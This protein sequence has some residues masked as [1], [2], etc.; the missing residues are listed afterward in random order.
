MGKLEENLPKLAKKALKEEDDVTRGL[1][2]VLL[3]QVYSGQHKTNLKTI[4]QTALDNEIEKNIDAG[5][6]NIN[7][8]EE[9]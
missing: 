9:N 1:V 7:N 6:I 5:I 8:L 2:N 4:V 3:N